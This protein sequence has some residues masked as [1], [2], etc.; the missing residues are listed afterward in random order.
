MVRDLVGVM[1]EAPPASPVEAVAPRDAAAQDALADANAHLRSRL[2][3]LALDLA[4]REGAAHASAWRIEELERLLA[5][6][7]AAR[8]ASPVAASASGRK[9]GPALSAALDEL[10]TLRKAFVQEHEARV[11][12]ESGEELARA[13][14]EI[15]RQAV[16]LNQLANQSEEDSR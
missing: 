7:S 4:R 14:V 5:Q 8:P 6:A 9:S 10:D 1:D 3:A 11:R 15:E 2:D 12:A 16:L 13:R